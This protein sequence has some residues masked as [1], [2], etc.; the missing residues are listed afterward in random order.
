MSGTFRVEDKYR[1]NP[2]SLSPG[3]GVVKVYYEDGSARIYDKIKYPR[4]YIGSLSR[5]DDA[6][7]VVR[8]DVDEELYWERTPTDHNF[9]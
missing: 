6:N 9:Y 8:I 2:M 4:R 5:R 7:R 3:G 1:T